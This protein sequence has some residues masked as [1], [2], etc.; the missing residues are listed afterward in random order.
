MPDASVT[1][2]RRRARPI[3]HMLLHEHLFD[4]VPAVD[5]LEAALQVLR[6][7]TADAACAADAG[8][9]HRWGQALARVRGWLDGVDGLL[10]R[11]AQ[12]VGEAGGPI[13]GRLFQ[14]EHGA[15]SDQGARAAVQRAGVLGEVPELAAGVASGRLGVAHADAVARAVAGAEPE[16]RSEVLGHGS[17]LAREAGSST[18][19]QLERTVRR[20]AER[21]RTGDGPEEVLARQRERSHLRR[22]VDREGM[23]HLYAALDA[24]RG[25]RVFRALDGA[26]EAA[27]HRAHP[28][29]RS[30]APSG[31]SVNERLSADALVELTT[32]AGRPGGAQGTELIVLIDEQTLRTGIEHHGTVAETG[33]GVPL[34]V[35]VIRQMLCTAGVLPVVLGGDGCVLDV[36]ATRRLATRAQR[37]AMRAMYRTCAV[38]GCTV[39]FDHCELHHLTPWSVVSRTDLEDLVPLCGTHHE[40][41]HRHGWLLEL[42]AQRNAAWRA[43]DGRIVDRQR[44]EPIGPCRL[45]RQRQPDPVVGQIRRRFDALLG[46]RRE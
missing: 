23:H 17:W 19:E 18:P 44:F 5:D 12:A 46:A 7:V 6:S 29:V 37:R 22:W 27:F 33:S 14:R 9:L 26:L 24:E 4:R 13:D 40:Q 28:D 20:E 2:R 34:P 25:A 43:P 10:T 35:S 36:G 3:E 16:V 32:G 8:Q 41:V 21:L 38:P 42:D 1:D 39:R 11:R 45:R 31:G 15:R 30:R